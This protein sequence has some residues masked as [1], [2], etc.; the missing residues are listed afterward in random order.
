M[1]VAMMDLNP[2]GNFQDVA[3]SRPGLPALAKGQAAASG[4]EARSQSRLGK[5]KQFP[6]VQPAAEKAAALVI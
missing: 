5:P 4:S 1:P 6:H 3:M 2:R